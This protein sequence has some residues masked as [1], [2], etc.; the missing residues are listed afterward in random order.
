M[1]LW[2]KAIIVNIL[3]NYSNQKCQHKQ[4]HKHQ[5]RIVMMA[6]VEEVA[7]IPKCF[8]ASQLSEFVPV[9]TGVSKRVRVGRRAGL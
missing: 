6:C 2:T 1:S 7:A 3:V 4:K 5:R 8:S 9:R